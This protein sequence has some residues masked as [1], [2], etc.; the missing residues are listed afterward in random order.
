MHDVTHPWTN[1]GHSAVVHTAQT[2]SRSTGMDIFLA[3]RIQT[4]EQENEKSLLSLDGG[5]ANERPWIDRVYI[6]LRSTTLYFRL[7]G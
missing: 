2:P 5:L 4:T 3:C 1:L 7:S 6:I